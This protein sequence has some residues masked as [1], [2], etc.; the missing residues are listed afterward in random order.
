MTFEIEAGGKSPEKSESE[1]AT[2]E[3]ETQSTF[4]NSPNLPDCPTTPKLVENIEIEEEAPELSEDYQEFEAKMSEF[5][6]ILGSQFQGLNFLVASCEDLS[7]KNAEI[8]QN[9]EGENECE[10][11]FVFVDE[12]IHFAE[13]NN[14][15][16]NLKQTQS[17]KTPLTGEMI[18]RI[19]ANHMPEKNMTDTQIPDC[20]SLIRFQEKRKTPT[21]TVR[22]V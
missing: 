8:D 6:Y 19:L 1:F 12:E 14:Q 7:D 15:P 11:K 13:E 17:S 18:C 10:V 20:H 9:D 21:C 22:L 5:D 16:E 3:A 2:I 4:S